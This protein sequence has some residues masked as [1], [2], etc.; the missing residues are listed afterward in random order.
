MPSIFTLK[1]LGLNRQPNQL[2]V[3]EGSLS[4]AKNVTIQRDGVL[5]SRR[6]FKLYGNEFGTSSDRAKQLISYKQR[7]LRHYSSTLQY[8]NGAG[9]FSSLAGSV[10]EPETGLRIKSI[11]ANGNLYFT[12]SDGI[13]KIS[14][15]TAADL[16]TASGVITNA[17]AVKAIDITGSVNYNY[18]DQTSFLTQ[19]SAVAYRVV[20]GYKDNNTN[21]LLGT[22]SQRIEVYNSLLTLLLQDYMHLLGAL[23][24]IGAL[25]AL[26]NDKNYVNT[27]KLNISASASDLLT[28]LIALATKIDNDILYAD[29]VAVA[30][31][32]IASATISSGICTVTFSSGDPSQY[33]SA[34]SKIYLAG[35][36]PGTSGVLN[37]AQTVASVTTTTLTFNTSATGIVTTSTPTIVSNN[38]R[39]ITQPA[40]PSIPPTNN[41]LVNLQNYILDIITQLIAEPTTVID[42]T[43]SSNYI[44]NLD[45]TKAS[46]VNLRITIPQDVNS[47]YFFQIY[48]SAIFEATGTQVL[49]ID[50][51]PNDELQLVY[52]A[53]PTSAEL[54][55]GFIEVEDIVPDDF[56]G[57]NLYT[58]ASTG[59]GILQANDVPPFAKDI[60]VFKNSVWYANTHTRHRLAVSLL[61][62]QS[63]ITDYNNGITPSITIATTSSYNTYKFIVGKVEIYDITCVAGASLAASGTGS[64][65]DVYSGED[66]RSYRLWY[67]IGTAVAPSS[68]GHTL[69]EVLA[70]AGDSSTDIA[71]KT[72]DALNRLSK[73]FSAT[74]S[75]NVVTVNLTKQ[76]YTT[77]ASAG[78][79]GHTINITQQGQ[80][81]NVSN[82]EILL[83][84]NVSP[85]IAVQDTA[86]SLT[87]VLNSNPSEN[88]YVYYTSGAQEVPGQMVFEARSLTNSQFGIVTNNANS[89][90]AFNPPFSPTLEI[91]SITTGSPTSMTVVTSSAHGLTNL[92][93]VY[94]SGSDCTPSI[95]GYH[96]ITYVDSTTFRVNVTVTVGGSKGGVIKPS[97]IETS[98]NEDFSNRIYYSKYQQPEAVPI[99]NY[100]DVGAKDKAIL[101][102]FP[103]R[104]SL[105]V[106]KEDGLYRISGESIPFNLAL[107][108]TSCILVAPDS[109]S[110]VDNVIYG[111]TRQGVA[112][113]T[114]SGTRNVSRPIDI[115]LLPLA[116]TV[117]PSFK[118]ATW[119][120]GYESDKSYTVFTVK[121]SSDTYAHQGF[122]F[123]TLT[124]TWTN[125]DKDYVCGVINFADDKMYVGVGDTNY[126]EQ[127]RKSFTR[128]DYA[129]REYVLSVLPNS[130]G[131]SI[132]VDSVNDI[133]V[134]DVI[135]QN[136]TLTVYFYN[137][138]LKKLDN[139]PGIPSSNYFS[140]LEAAT[141]N[142][143][144]S[145][146]V[147][148]AQKLDSDS[149]QFTNYETSIDT[150]SG[151]ISAISTGSTVTITANNHG[152]I[153]GRQVN[154]SATNSVPTINAQYEVTVIN[155]NTFTIQPGVTVTTAGTSG[156]YSTVT[157]DFD[158]LKVCYNQIIT[159]LNLDNIVA[160]ANYQQVTHST[161]Q[162]VLIVDINK[163]TKELILSQEVPFIQGEF[164]VYKSIPCEVIYSPNTF[165]GDPSSLKHMREAQLMFD[166]LAF[167]GG[168]VSFATDLLPMFESID[169]VADGNGIFG[170]TAFGEGFFGGGS[171]G[172]PIRTYIPR[173]CQRCRYMLVKFNH[174]VAREKWALFGIVLTGET[175]LSSR[176]YK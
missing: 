36:T 20:W 66:E 50:V 97:E 159:K 167:T 148:L 54:S 18:A 19:D 45:V 48:R 164:T 100:F 79:S 99:L 16:T 137:M 10:L 124:N 73:D 110:S 30:P 21:L 84:D 38:Y 6:G 153:T 134:D 107:F 168:T 69:V 75:T 94:I 160:F 150:L 98:S 146:L 120:L 33:V 136:Q 112:S 130:T 170:F 72:R 28:N 93:Y 17:G 104:D 172:A 119:G 7:I 29:D 81:E 25:G 13:K 173:N 74:A 92:D 32:Q 165:G 147:S 145:K 44:D 12:S 22:P 11:E 157:S 87:R 154:I 64:Y 43:V 37:G 152:L 105:F 55:A 140:L 8:D 95:D 86:Q 42:N 3:P 46:S 56:R 161:A 35:F 53:F 62:V 34:G 59:E 141:G 144:R 15:K 169:F 139:D 63:M 118:T 155:A 58:N 109:V 114:E 122:K 171:H 163:I 26:I 4:L 158:D 27:L 123:N 70:S 65:F 71:N 115:D 174:Q 149:L 175:Q 85:A 106:F 57:A 96:Q 133:D 143:L 162:E 47:N 132:F 101:R 68:G 108:D 90:T 76:G 117:Y 135:V 5:E 176:A 83:S 39:S 126:I 121:K 166:S 129:D 151:S 103:L 102:I 31:L 88:I 60:N 77:N 80:G 49:S 142:N 67:K 82:K 24:D 125:V 23:D 51:F 2:E 113:V 128:E 131:T 14:A 111:W 40:V 41:D 9:V 138:L 1:A 116:S 78:T 61:G 91:S 127:E 156:L 89:G 52:E